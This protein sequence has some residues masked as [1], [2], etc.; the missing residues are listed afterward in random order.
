MIAVSHWWEI[1]WFSPLFQVSFPD[2]TFYFP[3][4]AKFLHLTSTSLCVFIPFYCT[5]FPNTT[6]TSS[7]FLHF[8]KYHPHMIPCATNIYL[9]SG[10]KVRN[11]PLRGQVT[12]QRW[13][14]RLSPQIEPQV[15]GSIAGL[16]SFLGLVLS[17]QILECSKFLLYQAKQFSS[18]PGASTFMYKV[19]SSRCFPKFR[20]LGIWRLLSA[21]VLNSIFPPPLCYYSHF[22]QDETSL[23]RLNDDTRKM[24]RVWIKSLSWLTQSLC[25]F[26]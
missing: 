12:S 24:A 5:A 9:Y 14:L 16:F 26:H 10:E 25:S 3:T 23:V 7:Q 2:L 21:V 20:V 19:G 15:F 11:G 8:P 18:L 4:Q 13:L 17:S 6:N 1:C 22:T